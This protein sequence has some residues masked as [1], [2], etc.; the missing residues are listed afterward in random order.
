MDLGTCDLACVDW[1]QI[2]VVGG[3]LWVSPDY[4]AICLSSK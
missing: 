4:H 1:D 2:G 3:L